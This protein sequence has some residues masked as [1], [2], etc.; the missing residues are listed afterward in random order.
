MAK[1]KQK[2]VYLVQIETR[3]R[4]QKMKK[5]CMKCGKIFYNDC[6]LCD[7]CFCAD[8]EIGHENEKAL[9]FR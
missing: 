3:K 7:S 6:T 8:F 4:E 9:C 5:I 2:M 1:R